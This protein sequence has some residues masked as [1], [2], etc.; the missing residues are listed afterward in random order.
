[1]KENDEDKKFG[2]IASTIEVKTVE[3]FL[4]ENYLPYAYYVIRNRALVGVDGLKPVNRR[5][6]YS[7]Y[8]L[9]LG[10][11]SKTIKAQMILGD[12][13]GKY[14]PHGDSGISGGMSHMAQDFA[15]RVR[16]IEPEGSVGYSTGDRAAAPRYWEARLTK[17]AMELLR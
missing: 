8:L 1:M 14:H 4:H 6:V 12:V 7:M 17:P 11:S 3:D 2:Q 5:I 9:K 16:L 13:M 15:T 10:P